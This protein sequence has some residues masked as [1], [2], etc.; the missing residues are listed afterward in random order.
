[1]TKTDKGWRKKPVF[2]Y[3]M[4]EN[5][6]SRLKTQALS[7]IHAIAEYSVKFFADEL[8]RQGFRRGYGRTLKTV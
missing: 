7:Q 8:K 4:P 6:V 1:M 2:L 3:Q 5:T